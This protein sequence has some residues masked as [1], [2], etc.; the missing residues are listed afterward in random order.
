MTQSETEGC[1][2]SVA[3][4]GGA[5]IIQM[6]NTASAA[7]LVCGHGSG[8]HAPFIHWCYPCPNISLGPGRR[9]FTSEVS[10]EALLKA[11][12]HSQCHPGPEP[13]PR[14]LLATV[15]AERRGPVRAAGWGKMFP[16]VHGEPYC[17]SSQANCKRSDGPFWPV[18]SGAGDVAAYNI[19][20]TLRVVLA[21]G[22]PS[23]PGLAL[24]LVVTLLTSH[25]LGQDQVLCTTG[26]MRGMAHA[27]TG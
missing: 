17:V 18:R 15:Q 10:S 11:S 20:T 27:A 2:T 6:R 7:K 9:S 23:V 16:E 19:H 1:F 25:F 21:P 24:S 13:V 4:P 12:I 3:P 26:T 22:W 14:A 5:R 8:S